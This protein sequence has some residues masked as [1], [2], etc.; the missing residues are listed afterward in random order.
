G[1]VL[2]IRRDRARVLLA[3]DAGHEAGSSLRRASRRVRFSVRSA[4][5]RPK[6][7]TAFCHKGRR[8]SSPVGASRRASAIPV[9]PSATALAYTMLS[10]QGASDAGDGEAGSGG[11]DQTSARIE[12]G[13]GCRGRALAPGDGSSDGG[14]EPALPRCHPGRAG[15]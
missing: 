6:D 10:R 11:A 7:H 14:G 8:Y 12:Q 1:D 13:T 5:A 9:V 3:E 4:A 15:G 2:G